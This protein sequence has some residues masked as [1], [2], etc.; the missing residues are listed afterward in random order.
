MVNKQ[1]KTQTSKKNT[2]EEIVL[3]VSDLQTHFYTKWGLVKA[4]DGVSFDLKKGE[5][6]AV[7]GESGSGKSVTSLSIMQLIPSPPGFIVGGEVNLEGEN[8]L[9]KSIHKFPIFP[10]MVGSLE[11]DLSPIITLLLFFLRSKTGTVLMLIPTFFKKSVFSK[12][13]V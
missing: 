11:K 2:N 1:S 5:T 4:V 13:T 8:L 7:V 9:N 6:L 12:K 3:S 10:T